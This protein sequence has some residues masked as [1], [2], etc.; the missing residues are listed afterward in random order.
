MWLPTAT[1]RLACGRSP[2]AP[3]L[4]GSAQVGVSTQEL[5]GLGQDVPQRRHIHCVQAGR[6]LE[7]PAHDRHKQLQ[8]SRL[9]APAGWMGC[10]VIEVVEGRLLDMLW[11]LGPLVAWLVRRQRRPDLRRLHLLLEAPTTSGPT[12]GETA[13]EPLSDG[14]ADDPPGDGPSGASTPTVDRDLAGWAGE[15]G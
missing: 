13:T 8:G 9:V 2:D 6:L 15:Q 4:P 7:W 5:L 12:L 11:P 3:S 1:L 14:A 10:R